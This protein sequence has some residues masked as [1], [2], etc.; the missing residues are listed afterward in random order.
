MNKIGSLKIEKFLEDLGSK[1]PTPGGGAV[2][3][4]TGAMAASLVEMVANLTIGKKGYEKV[5]TESEKIRNEALILKRELL[6]LADADVKVFN[7]VMAAYKSKDKEEIKKAL[8]LAIEVPGEVARLSKKVGNLAVKVARIGN[9][10]AYSDA[11][12]AHHLAQA[13]VDSAGEN[14]RINRKALEAVQ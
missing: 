14:I 8:K 7:R 2:A 11:K 9:K 5:N 12:S 1:S 6:K 4:L 13:A 10:H 3:A